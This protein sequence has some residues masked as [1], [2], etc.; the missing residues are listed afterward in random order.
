[1][2]EEALKQ[3]LARRWS[4]PHAVLGAHAIGN[5]VVFRALRPDAKAVTVRIGEKTLPLTAL[6][7][8]PGVFEGTLK[9]AKPTPYELELE[10]DGG[11]RSREKDP[12]AFL[13]TLGAA[14]LHFVGEGR[15]RR[16]WERLGAHP[17][18][19]QGVAGV[20]FVVW[21]PNAFA[22]ALVGDFNFWSDQRHPMRTLGPSGLWEIFI[23]G[24]TPGQR[25]K[26][27]VF[28]QRGE[29]FLK[30]DPM[31]FRTEMPPLS[32]SVVQA[33]DG[34]HWG[35]SKWLG[36][37]KQ[38]DSKH[39]AISIYEVHLGSWARVSGEDNRSLTYREMAPRLAVGLVIGR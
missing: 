4:D 14:D 2:R 35:D 38:T 26:F 24:A 16:L 5:D 22:V 32:A 15:H 29:P 34:Y 33:L 28:P 3:L 11:F 1:V 21:A 36:A 12:F 25:Y 17:I 30:A 37:R 13:P 27:L 20:S 31:A 19:H 8:F 18:T 6:P 7:D 9:A 23:P 10:F 39:A